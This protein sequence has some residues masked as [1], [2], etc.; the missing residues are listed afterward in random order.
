[1]PNVT[2][3]LE[4][5]QPLYVSLVS[6]YVIA[7]PLDLGERS[8]S[9]QFHRDLFPILISNFRHL[10]SLP[11]YRAGLIA[12]GNWRC[13][14][15][16]RSPSDRPLTGH[17]PRR[18]TRTRTAL[19]PPLPSE[20]QQLLSDHLHYLPRAILE[21]QNRIVLGDPLSGETMTMKTTSTKVDRVQDEAK[22]REKTKPS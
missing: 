8:N 3:L 12:A 19:L 5:F 17:P 4:A 22:E 15:L 21:D 20:F 11:R 1:M 18:A 7:R 2:W 14:H 10:S 13:Q 16:S 9:Y 6:V